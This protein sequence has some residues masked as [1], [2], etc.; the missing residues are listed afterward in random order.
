MAAADQIRKELRQLIREM[1][2]LSHNCLNSGM[3]LAQAHILS[4]LNQN[5]ITPF[6]ELQ[7]QL[8]ID[9]AALSRI[10]TI[11]RR[12]Q[13]IMIQQDESDKRAKKIELLPLGQRNIQLADVEATRYIKDILHPFNHKSAEL[14]EA[15][16]TIRLLVLRD[17]IIK[18]SERVKFER[19]SINYYDAAIILASEV[20]YL[21]QKIPKELV[22]VNKEHQPIWWCARVGEDIVAVVAS[23]VENGECH[24]G[25]FAVDKRL[26]GLGIG[27]QMAIT[28]LQDIFHLGADHVYLEARD[29]TVS[30]INKMGGSAV[31]IKRDFY[32]QPVTP[33]VL[34][35][36][37]FVRSL[38]TTLMQKL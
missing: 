11:L 26:R 21:E 15:L 3:T 5:G 10:L 22:P 8:G 27:A 37:D 17:N 19:L 18:Q 20:F 29:I 31:D 1:G 24:W 36:V 4:Y 23:W 33:M 25:R 16:K 38:G 34:A 9:K 12:K 28:S 35:K 30:L 2:L 13:Y 14:A 32:G 7:L 6:G